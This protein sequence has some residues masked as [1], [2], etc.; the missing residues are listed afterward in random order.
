MKLSLLFSILFLGC[1]SVFAQST[2]SWDNATI[3]FTY[4][5][6]FYNADQ[7][8]DH[9]YGRINDYGDELKNVAT[10]HGG[11]IAGV[12]EKLEQGYF[13]E[14]GINVIWITGMY[15]QMHGWVGGGDKNDF[16]HYGYHGY[17]PMDFTALDK[18]FGTVAEFRQFVD[19]AHQQNI[20]VIMDAGLNH[21]GYHTLL[22]A[23]QYQFG[24]V[25]LSEE[26]A[27]QHHSG[28]LTS[29]VAHYEKYAYLQHFNTEHHSQ[30]ENWWG[31]DWIRASSDLDK[32]VLTESIFGLA[33]F[34]T[35]KKE[36]VALPSLLVNKWQK[37]GESFT[38]WVVPAAVKYR[39]NLNIAPADYLVT[40]LIAWVEEF[41]IDG[42]RLDVLDNVD[43]YRWEQLHK[44]SNEALSLWRQKNQHKKAAHW[45]EEFY[46]TGDIWGAGIDLFPK[47]Q[48]A[49]LNSIVNFTFPKD[50]NLK[51]IGKTWQQ[52]A[53][54]LNSQENWSTISFLNNTYKRDTDDNNMIN[55]GTSLLLSPGAIQI[56][57]G[58]EVGRKR[59]VQY[60][61]DITH[62]FRSDLLWNKGKDVLTHW[63]KLGTFRKQHISV[64][65]GQ[66]KTVA[67]NTYIRRYQVED[68]TDWVL[69]KLTEQSSTTIALTDILPNGT[70]L[71]N[72]YTGEIKMVTNGRVSF[73]V[74]NNVLILEKL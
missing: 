73:N 50:G 24:D 52:Y 41:G 67:P 66:Q 70:Q 71:K 63:Q 23:V 14:L 65:A 64:G 51:V 46:L 53:E 11:D 22:D 28:V 54:A 55:A 72:A 44:K 27:A 74:E 32:D 43:T 36:P 26:Q 40:W 20:R 57:Y 38:P 34:K 56:F 60:A 16:P 10:F 18:N 7:S 35:E 15:E 48:A 5:D 42:F 25:K 29:N 68:V 3:Y 13:N 59:T 21:P 17:Y 1:T 39:K 37:E 8:N 58:D 45:Q 2:F 12:S 62:G 6:R 47:Y 33:D 49:G 61:S 19:L 30:W 4:V 31:E 69:I 9:N